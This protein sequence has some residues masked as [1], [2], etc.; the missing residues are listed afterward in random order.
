MGRSKEGLE[1]RKAVMGFAARLAPQDPQPPHRGHDGR[2]NRPHELRL[3]LRGALR[4]RCTPE[5]IRDAAPG[6]GVLGHA[7]SLGRLPHRPRGA[8]RTHG[9]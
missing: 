5:E 6:G 2:P 1:V 9:P 3:H 7:R 8:P 4:N